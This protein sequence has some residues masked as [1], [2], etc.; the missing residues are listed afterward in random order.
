MKKLLFTFIISILITPSLTFAAGVSEVCTTPLSISNCDTGLYCEVYD[1]MNNINK[2]L[3][4][5]ATGDS[6]SGDFE[7]QTNYCDPSTDTCQI[8]P[9]PSATGAAP[10][11]QTGSTPTVPAA[12]AVTL[13]NPLNTTNINSIIGRLIKYIIGISGSIALAIFIYGGI[14]WI[15]SAGRNEYVEKGKKALKNSTLGLVIIF[16]SYIVIRFIIEAFESLS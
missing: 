9:G 6:C 8:N 12:G 3:E 11:S 13:S 10:E 1:A 16:T 4:Q 15:I 7:F 14:L 5:T 2:C